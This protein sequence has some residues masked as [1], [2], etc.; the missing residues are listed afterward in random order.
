LETLLF[1]V[2][3]VKLDLAPQRVVFDRGL[4]S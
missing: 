3:E 1:G 2:P 4:A